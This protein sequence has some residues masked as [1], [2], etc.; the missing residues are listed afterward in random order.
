MKALLIA[1]IAI[2]AT[3]ALADGLSVKSTR[4]VPGAVQ[5][6]DL[7]ISP[8]PQSKRSAAVWAGTNCWN[9]CQTNCGAQFSMCNTSYGPDACRPALDACDRSCQRTCRIKGGPLLPLD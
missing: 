1:L 7:H 6:P 2:I 8:Y 4:A 3:P 9:D 5:G